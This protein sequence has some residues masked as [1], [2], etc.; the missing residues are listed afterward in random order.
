VWRRLIPELHAFHVVSRR[1]RM[2]VRVTLTKL[3][4]GKVQVRVSRPEHNRTLIKDYDSE[5][6]AREF[7]LEVEVPKDALDF[8]FRQLLPQ[9]E[10]NQELAFPEM[11]IPEYELWW[12]GFS[13]C[14]GR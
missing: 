14:Q 3:Y 7:L 6:E 4:G 13:I 1:K 9:L 10:E 5:Q 2:F 11:N 8:Y 12:R